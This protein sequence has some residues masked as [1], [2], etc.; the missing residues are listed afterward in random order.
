MLETLYNIELRSC[1]LGRYW[2]IYPFIQLN[3]HA[4]VHLFVHSCNKHLLSAYHVPG[5]STRKMIFKGLQSDGGDRHDMSAVPQEVSVKDKLR[6]EALEVG[7][8]PYRLWE[9]AQSSPSKYLLFPPPWQLGLTPCVLYK[10]EKFPTGV[11][12]LAMNRL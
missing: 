4:S 9:M 1:S 11:F 10:G 3:T 6:A 2:F 5:A 7:C 8:G 12:W